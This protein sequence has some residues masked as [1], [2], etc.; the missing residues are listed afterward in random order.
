[1]ST[2]AESSGRLR[3]LTATVAGR[4]RR[5]AVLLGV[6]F[7]LALAAAALILA[8][9][10]SHRESLVAVLR[11]TKAIRA[12]SAISANELGVTYVHFQ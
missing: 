1:M 8:G 4:R 7:F 12:G 2:G 3:V 5:A 11:A 6:L 9:P 10:A